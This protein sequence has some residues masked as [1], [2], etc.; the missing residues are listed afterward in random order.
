MKKQED[1]KIILVGIGV[2]AILLIIL[3]SLK[4]KS[5]C[6]RFS[7]CLLNNLKILIILLSLIDN[8]LVFL[9]IIR[10][11]FSYGVKATNQ[12]YH[13]TEK[14]GYKTITLKDNI[15]KDEFVSGEYIKENFEN[16]KD[17]YKEHYEK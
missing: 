12:L 2:L 5:M 17:K 10:V 3:L 13:N 16:V 15:T 1:N 8:P 14:I 9:L 11:I 7:S 6:F 4:V